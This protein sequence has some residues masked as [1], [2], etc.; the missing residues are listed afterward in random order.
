MRKLGIK[1]ASGFLIAVLLSVGG[2]TCYGNLFSKET[3]MMSYKDKLERLSELEEKKAVFVGGSA[4]HFGISAEKF[5]QSTGIQSV[6]M[7][8]HASI[9][10]DTYLSTVIPFLKEG[11]LLFI[12]P[13]YDYYCTE[14]IKTDSQNTE[15]AVY[16]NDQLCKYAF[17]S[18]D[19]VPNLLY[20]GWNQWSNICKQIISLKLYGKTTEAYSR[21]GSNKWGDYTMNN[22]PSEISSSYSTLKG[23]NDESM[24][25]LQSY[26]N[27]I[28]NNGI[29]VY[30]LFPPYLDSAY[31]V[32]KVTI[33]EVYKS[34]ENANVDLLFEPGETK[35]DSSQFF[36][37]VY[38]LNDNGRNRYTQLLIE[39]FNNKME[40]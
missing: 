39:K 15:F 10:M 23:I 35:Y 27:E 40:K 17:S 19:A 37:T 30:V 4:T 13:E 28:K 11:D 6:N 9:S 36:D 32:N 29:Q 38:H 14:W 5:E 12:T 25:K 16:Y 1:L 8:L 34:L 20:T 3:H 22:H 21:N 7:G 2:Y 33:N 18:T 31:E 26:I 24:K